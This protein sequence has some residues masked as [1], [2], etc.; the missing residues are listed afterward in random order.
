MKIIK[1]IAEWLNKELQSSVNE[2]P[3]NKPP[4]NLRPEPKDLN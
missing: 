3:V 2:I 1:K 4:D